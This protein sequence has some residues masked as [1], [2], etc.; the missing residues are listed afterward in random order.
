MDRTQLRLLPGE[1]RPDWS[2][3]ARG[4]ISP[5][6]LALVAGFVASG[7][8][9]WQGFG[10]DRAGVFI[11]VVCGWLITLCLHEFMHAATAYW[12]GDH[13]V[14]GKGYLRLDPM[15]YG[16][17]LLTFILPVV[18]LLIGGLPLPGGAV[19]IENHR[20]RSRLRTSLTSLAG[21]AVN[22]VAAAILLVVLNIGGIGLARSHYAL[23]GGLAFLAFLQIATAILN[24][25]PIPGLDGYGVIEPYLGGE[26]RRL[27][28]QIRPYG[29]LIM[30]ALLFA[31]PE[32]R[33]L[34]GDWTYKV[35]DAAGND[36]TKYGAGVGSALFQF[37]RNN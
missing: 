15:R 4:P 34:I 22:I 23:W 8:A 13:T 37:W 2:A 31:I 29:L 24:L 28:D 3:S 36:L 26:A 33:H 25:V 16:H 21:P 32:T 20:L 17:P 6:F 30:F 1:Y 9:L 10:S 11:F 5:I 27:G 35:M 18:Y 19:L 12:G 14:A 7:V